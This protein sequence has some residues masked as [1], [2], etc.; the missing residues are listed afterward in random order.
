LLK[1][2]IETLKKALRFI[3]DEFFIRTDGGHYEVLWFINRQ[4]PSV[5]Q[6]YDFDEERFGLTKDGRLIWGFDSGC[7]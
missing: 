7:S 1:T 6:S 3:P 4:K 2:K 5:S